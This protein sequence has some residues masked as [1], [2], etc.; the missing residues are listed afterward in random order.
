MTRDADKIERALWDAKFASEADRDLVYNAIARLFDYERGQRMLAVDSPHPP[1]KLAVK[2]IEN[3]E[4][5][6]VFYLDTERER[7]DIL[8]WLTGKKDGA[9]LSEAF[10]AM[11]EL[12]K[13]PPFSEAQ[14]R[15]IIAETEEPSG[16]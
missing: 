9:S 10:R 14:L 5:Q 1:W 16:G 6:Q 13:P 2:L 12:E 7:P 8:E 4:T 15:E 3:G 11:L